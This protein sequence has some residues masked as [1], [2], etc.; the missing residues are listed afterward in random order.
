MSEF[1]SST[2]LL[3]TA[4]GAAV[5]VIASAEE[6]FS[7]ILKVFGN[8]STPRF[9]IDLPK[10][11]NEKNSTDINISN[12]FTPVKNFINRSVSV[13]K[14][15]I[16]VKYNWK[17]S[18]IL[19]VILS[20]IYL[21]A[22]PYWT[23]FKMKSAI[24]DGKTELL[25]KYIEFDTLRDNIKEQINASIA[26]S[27]NSEEMADNPFAGLGV[28]FA[29]SIGEKLIDEMITPQ[30]IAKMLKGGKPTSS[31]SRKAV[32]DPFENVTTGYTGFNEFIVN[33]PIE[34]DED[35]KFVFNRDFLSWKLTNIS[36]P[37]QK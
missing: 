31:N 15:K 25:S 17:Y 6:I 33:V 4:L 20:I 3:L 19:V 28:S 12:I 24:L 2:I 7:F 14:S 21:Y 9:N 37:Y 32:S 36:I 5:L 35:V 13:I 27:M 16:Q 11:Q 23:T 29:K 22:S 30:A 10:K 1:E 34:G 8:V 26:K 18:L